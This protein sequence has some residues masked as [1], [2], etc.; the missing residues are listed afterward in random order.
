[1]QPGFYCQVSKFD[2]DHFQGPALI[3]VLLQIAPNYCIRFSRECSLIDAILMRIGY[4]LHKDVEDILISMFHAD[5]EY[6][7]KPRTFCLQQYE[8]AI[9]VK[10]VNTQTQLI[11]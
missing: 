11:T 7:K 1:M 6:F 5:S 4:R 9:K 8:D 2:V 10:N 3:L